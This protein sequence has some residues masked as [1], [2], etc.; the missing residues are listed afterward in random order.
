[1]TTYKLL[2]DTFPIFNF[3]DSNLLIICGIIALLTAIIT[4]IR[5][6]PKSTILASTLVTGLA[7]FAFLILTV[8]S[9]S[10]SPLGQHIRLTTVA[11]GLDAVL[12][13][14][15][16]ITVTPRSDSVTIQYKPVVS[17]ERQF[18]T[19][20][21]VDSTPNSVVIS[22]ASYDKIL[23]AFQQTKPEGALSLMR[24]E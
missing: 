3:L 21:T 15:A 9:L 23:T 22:K 10:L 16:T 19:E 1:M 11:S 4:A 14:K 8:T 6:E 17:T 13:D 24:N 5:K 7:S 20:I 2:Q 18:G 12:A